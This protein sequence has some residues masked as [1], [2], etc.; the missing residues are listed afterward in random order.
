M[1]S[2]FFVSLLT[3]CSCS[4]FATNNVY[5]CT[6]HST[7]ILKM[8]DK[9]E[10]ELAS[11]QSFQLVP[12]QASDN[13]NEEDERSS[14][15]KLI[16]EGKVAGTNIGVTLY[17]MGDGT[18]N[19]QLDAL[20]QVQSRVKWSKEKETVTSLKYNSSFL[21]TSSKVDNGLGVLIY[22]SI[23]SNILFRVFCH[24]IK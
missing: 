2:L 17:D 14:Y 22:R 10:K 19:I 4:L 7:D 24:R 13:L 5:E 1:K 11:Q 18:V 15:T 16:D 23:G 6:S 3:I 20:T 21:L 8:T 9:T 12:M